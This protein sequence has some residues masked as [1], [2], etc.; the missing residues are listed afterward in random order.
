M[1]AAAA[2]LDFERAARI[3]DE[4]RALRVADLGLAGAVE[5]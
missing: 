4:I 3:R 5:R 1:K 2:D